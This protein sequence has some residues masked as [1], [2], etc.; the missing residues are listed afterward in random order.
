E[1]LQ[2]LA[3]LLSAGE[4]GLRATTNWMLEQSEMNN[5][6]AGATPYLRAFALVLGGHY[7]LKAALAEGAK[8]PRTELARFFIR[9]HVIQHDALCSQARESDHSLYA[10]SS[11]E[12]AG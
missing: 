5:R 11:T 10:L 9:Q 12:L 3:A 2:D 8:G 1:N 7:L 4:Q 6:F